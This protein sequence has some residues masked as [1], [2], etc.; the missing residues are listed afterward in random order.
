MGAADGAGVAQ[1]LKPVFFFVLFCFKKR[2]EKM[3]I[4]DVCQCLNNTNSGSQQVIKQAD[5][6]ELCFLVS[7][8]RGHAP[9]ASPGRMSAMRTEENRLTALL[10]KMGFPQIHWVVA[11]L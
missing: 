4:S 1:L 6:C 10:S 5:N 9:Q 2:K 8:Y 11:E 7:V 3:L